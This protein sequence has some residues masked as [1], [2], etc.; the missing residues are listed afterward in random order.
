MA[1]V[2]AHEAL[3]ALARGRPS[4]SQHVGGALLE[5][6]TKHVVMTFGLVVE[7]RANPQQKFLGVLE[8]AGTC[9]ALREKPRIGQHRNRLGAE[10][11]AET[12]R[13]FLHVRF[14]LIQRVV[15]A[16][17]PFGN[18]RLER[19]ERSRGG[20]ARGRKR[21]KTAPAAPHRRRW[22]ARRSARAETP[23]CRLRAR[24]PPRTSRT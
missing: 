24:R 16:R 9:A 1:E 15:E 12:A 7:N 2:V 23:G 4:V 11:I 13:R 20:L 21:Q 8:R 17:V 10:Q 5:L 3:D 22:R 19:I 6:V 18:Q 14:E